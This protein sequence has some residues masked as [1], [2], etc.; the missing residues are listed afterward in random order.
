MA[1][2]EDVAKPA[3]EQ[4][5][6]QL[7]NLINQL[8]IDDLTRKL[9][10]QDKNLAE[11]T[12]IMRDAM[13][14]INH[15]ILTNRGGTTGVHGFIAEA[16]EV[17]VK[18]AKSAVQGKKLL[19]SWV[20]DN[21]PVD[22]LRENTPLQL[23]FVETGGKFSLNAVEEH[24]QKYP[25]FIKKGGKYVIPKDF[26]EKIQRVRNMSPQEAA[27]LTKNSDIT[28]SQYRSIREMLHNHKNLSSKIEPAEHSY[29]DVQANQIHK[30][31]KAQNKAIHE[32]DQKIR[33]DIQAEHKPNL[34]EGAQATV[35]GAALEG[36]TSFA[37]A[38]KGKLGNGKHLSDITQNEWI[39]IL[40]DT[41][42]GTAKGAIRGSSVYLM[43][44]ALHMDGTVAT[45]AVTA[46]LGI[47]EAAFKFRNHEITKDEFISQ[48]EMVCMDSAVSAIGSI[49]GQ[50]LIPVPIVGPLV[51][52]AV[53]TYM[54]SIVKDVLKESKILNEYKE[55]I[56]ALTKQL[57]KE[58][59]ECIEQINQNMQEYLEILSR[60][61][62][63]DIE[64]AFNG[65]IELAQTLGVS[66]NEI[67]KNKEEI[68]N[69]F[70]D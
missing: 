58:Y 36:A 61:F 25:E 12:Q 3:E 20:D 9:T 66:E 59:Q 63:P 52:N 56:E 8:R 62:S 43:T 69:Y 19:Y 28:P 32:E 29:A 11:A 41:G 6:G 21:G 60:A 42:I 18:N 10:T 44:N 50:A 70:L 23:K 1:D 47:A 14:K 39:D 49:L 54:Y 2:I 37:I 17:G 22:L 57:D 31:M 24:L 16:A 26:Y 34:K 38:I 45:S 64:K 51:G 55:Q 4:L 65:S 67:L 27:R 48:A 7:V 15:I 5:V 68:D 30:T 46:A 35:I 13:G 53:A 33:A 40:K